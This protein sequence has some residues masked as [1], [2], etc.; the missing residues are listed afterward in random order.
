MRVGDGSAAVLAVDEVVHH[1]GLQ[2]T[3]TE[4]RD[5]RH[6]VVEA[7]GLEPPDEILHAP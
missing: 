6:D 4:Q 5:E 1:A 7:I 2:G 3:R